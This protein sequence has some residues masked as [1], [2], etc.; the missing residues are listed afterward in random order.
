MTD[1]IILPYITENEN[2]GNVV[3]AVADERLAEKPRTD[4]RDWVLE[5]A[6]LVLNFEKL[7]PNPDLIDVHVHEIERDNSRIIRVLWSVGSVTT[8]TDS[9]IRK[10]SSL[11]AAKIGAS[12]VTAV[13]NG[14]FITFSIH[15]EVGGPTPAY[16]DPYTERFSSPETQPDP[17]NEK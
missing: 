11:K 13:T 6:A 5:I 8:R 12:H 15:K 4:Y 1:G 3:I 14:N 17:N 9:E 10:V 2:P 16:P 7:K